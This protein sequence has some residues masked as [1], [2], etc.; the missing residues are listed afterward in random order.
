MSDRGTDIEFD[1]FDEPETEEATRARPR[2]PRRPGPPRPPMRPATGFTPLLRLVGLIAFAIV[3]IVLLVFW[4]NSCR[5]EGKRETYENYLE[6]M[7]AIAGDSANVGRDLNGA[8]TTPGIKAADLQQTLAGLAQQQE[9]DVV[10]ARQLEPPGRLRDHHEQ[11]VEAL[12]FRASGLRSLQ[13]AFRQAPQKKAAEVGELL[14]APMRRLAASDVIWAD[15]FVAASRTVMREQDIQG[16]Q[17]PDSLFLADPDLATKRNM[18]QI[19][20]RIF[21]ASAGQPVTGR[22][23]NG[24]VSVRALPSG[25]VLQRDAD[26]FIVAT[27]DLRFEVTLE[28]SG[29]AQEVR[30]KVRLTV[31]QSPRPIRREQTVNIIDPGERQ[32]VVFGNLSDIVQFDQK[33]NMKVE[34]APVPGEENLSNNSATYPVTFTLT[35]P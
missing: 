29:E 1:F 22:H 34:I 15:Q 2:A 4:V 19:G 9:Q 23:G 27:V 10:R 7:E 35:P 8:L 31:P 18:E 3:I 17:V 30:V 33:V 13:D 21:G 28:N 16:I 32:T 24:L 5:A 25:E 26:N 12:Q 20:K 14:A 6:A 11:A